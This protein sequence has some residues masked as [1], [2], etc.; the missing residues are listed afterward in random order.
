MRVEKGDVVDALANDPLYQ[1]SASD[2]DG[3]HTG[4]LYW[5]LSTHLNASTPLTE[6]SHSFYGSIVKRDWLG[7]DLYVGH[8]DMGGYDPLG[9]VNTS[10]PEA[11]YVLHDDTKKIKYHSKEPNIS[12][13][14]RHVPPDMTHD[15]LADILAEFTSYTDRYSATH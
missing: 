3:F 11:K 13:I 9:A 12:Y 4:M 7:L 1:L 6:I 8:D 10:T 14:Y 15:E 2:Q 5:L